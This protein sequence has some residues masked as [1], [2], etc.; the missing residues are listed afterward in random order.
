[1]CGLKYVLCGLA[2]SVR[3]AF[4]LELSGCYDVF[5][6]LVTPCCICMLP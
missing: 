3:P 6:V 2:V 1:M 5:L 4:T